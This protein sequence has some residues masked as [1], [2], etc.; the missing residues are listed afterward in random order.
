MNDDIWW[1][2]ICST[3]GFTVDYINIYRGHTLSQKSVPIMVGI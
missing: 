1:S 3:I 2:G